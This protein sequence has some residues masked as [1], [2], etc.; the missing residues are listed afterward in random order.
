VRSINRKGRTVKGGGDSLFSAMTHGGDGDIWK[1]VVGGEPG[2]SG[3]TRGQKKKGKKRRGKK[4]RNCPVEDVHARDSP[5]PG[6]TVKN[7]RLL[8][9]ENYKGR[10]LFEESQ[11]PK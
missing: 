5:P 8:G 11:A 6:R 2:R 9:N 7:P 1:K 10:E 4:G 3:W